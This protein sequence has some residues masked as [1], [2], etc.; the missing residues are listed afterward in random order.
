V[1]GQIPDTGLPVG[2]I[3][4]YNATIETSFFG[5]IKTG[6]WSPES[7]FEQLGTALNLWGLQIAKSDYSFVS[8]AISGNV[9]IV[10]TLQ[11]LGPQT[12]AQPNDI[13]SIVDGAIGNI[14][15]GSYVT[16]SNISDWTIPQSA[17]GS[18]QTVNTGAPANQTSI[19][20][21]A[22]STVGIDPAAIGNGISNAVKN[23]T[24]GLG[25]GTGIIVIVLGVVAVF[26][27]VVVI[28]PTAPGR[29]AAGFA[30]RG[31]R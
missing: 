2:T 4:T 7:L 12:Y 8:A 30:H 15:G 19:V 22:L 9:P 20:S 28:S 18:G 27:V 29:A 10:L 16:G 13:R 23:A 17:G 31:R 21:D 6:I 25:L 1:A 24:S 11:M 14:L 5:A 3:L 26:A